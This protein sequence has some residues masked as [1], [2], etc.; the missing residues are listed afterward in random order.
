MQSSALPPGKAP[1]APGT[2]LQFAALVPLL[3][4]AERKDASQPG[5]P[6]C[7]KTKHKIRDFALPGE[8]ADLDVGELTLAGGKKKENPQRKSPQR[9]IL[10]TNA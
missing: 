6:P 4:G 5:A 3:R 1:P 10:L 7:F 2:E 9:L 8:A